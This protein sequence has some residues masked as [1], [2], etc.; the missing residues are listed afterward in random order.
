MNHKDDIDF[1]YLFAFIGLVGVVIF[2]I[3]AVLAP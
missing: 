1:D 2:I 3:L